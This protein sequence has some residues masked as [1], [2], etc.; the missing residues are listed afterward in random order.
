M[1]HYR[2]TPYITVPYGI[3]YCLSFNNIVMQ[4]TVLMVTV[5]VFKQLINEQ[6]V[7]YEKCT[8]F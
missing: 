6:N 1:D 4:R 3:Q 2:H 5:T 7:A 8:K